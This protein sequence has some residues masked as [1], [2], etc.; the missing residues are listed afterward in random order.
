MAKRVGSAAKSNSRRCFTLVSV[1]TPTAPRTP[2]PTK[3]AAAEKH[4]ARR[5]QYVDYTYRHR[6]AAAIASSDRAGIEF[7]G[8]TVGTSPVE[9]LDRSRELISTFN[10]SGLS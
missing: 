8:E 1:T 9:L 2:L 5:L 7:S 10:A 4:M 3:F 6:I